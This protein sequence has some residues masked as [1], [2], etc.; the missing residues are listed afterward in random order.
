MSISNVFKNAKTCC[1]IYHKEIIFFLSI[2]FLF[3]SSLVG[4]CGFLLFFVGFFVVFVGFF[5]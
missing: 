1:A 3:S 4:F 2:F 5:F